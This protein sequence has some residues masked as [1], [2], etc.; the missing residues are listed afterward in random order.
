[1][2]QIKNILFVMYDQLRHDYLSCAGHPTLRTPNFDRLAA[3]GVRFT[4]A[5]VQSPIC[6]ASRMC[7]YTGRYVHS[8][9]AAW[10]NFPL[11]VGE[12]T[13]GAHLRH[14]LRQPV[15]AGCEFGQR[16]HHGGVGRGVLLRESE[17]FA[18]GARSVIG[19]CGELL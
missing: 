11:K 18:R 4:R 10:N 3:R 5:Y 14:H 6:G 2:T 13:L 9:G 7:F 12:M 1:M 17:R 15:T 19:A 16:A 8:H